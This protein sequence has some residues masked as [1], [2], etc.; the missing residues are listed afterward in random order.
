MV[1]VTILKCK[2]C[3]AVIVVPNK[4]LFKIGKCTAC[5]SKNIVNLDEEFEET[6]I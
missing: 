2:D 6:E 5:Q 3:G 4:E 1:E